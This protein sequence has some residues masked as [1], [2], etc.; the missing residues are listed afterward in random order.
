MHQ[1]LTQALRHREAR[2]KVSPKDQVLEKAEHG[3][4]QAGVTGEILHNPAQPRPSAAGDLPT[5]WG[6]LRN[7]CWELGTV[8]YCRDPMSAATAS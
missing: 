5:C 3:I 7:L 1:E 6:D 4:K 8:C 2:C